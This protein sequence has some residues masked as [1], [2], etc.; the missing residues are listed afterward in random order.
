MTV[1][2]VDFR[3]AF[4]TVSHEKLFH[5]LRSYGIA[6]NLLSWLQNLYSGRTHRTRVGMSLSTVADLLSGVI[7]GSGIGP[8]MF[9]AFINEL[10]ELMKRYGVTI[11]LFADDSKLYAEIVDISDVHKFQ[12][13]LDQ[14]SD[15][16]A[17]WQLTIAIDKCCVL[18]VG[19]I[20]SDIVETANYSIDGHSLPL[21]SSCRD[22]GIIVSHD[23][24]PRLHINA[25]VLR[26]QQR[27]NVILRCFISRDSRLFIRAFS[28]P[29]WSLTQL[30]GRLI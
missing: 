9:L 27:A 17:T 18:N 7:Q 23:M 16:A 25:M 19:K 21:V 22:L 8:L 12:A 26:A 13:A 11:K 2:Y 24:S 30:C 6:G 14:L 15:W 1:A 3:K 20:P 29:Y 28:G 4:D 10:I 5:R